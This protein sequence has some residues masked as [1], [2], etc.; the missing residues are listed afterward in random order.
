LGKNIGRFEWGGGGVTSADVIKVE[1]YGNINRRMSK[2][3]ENLKEK[4]SKGKEKNK[5][6]LKGYKRCKKSKKGKKGV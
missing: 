5:L 4:G 2:S 1:K 3:G 6:K